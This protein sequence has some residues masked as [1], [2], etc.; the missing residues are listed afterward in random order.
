MLHSIYHLKHSTTISGVKSGVFYL[1][2]EGGEM[3]D[4]HD[5][6]FYLVFSTTVSAELKFFW[7]KLCMHTQPL[8]EPKP[9]QS[10]EGI[11]VPKY[12]LQ[13]VLIVLCQILPCWLCGKWRIPNLVPRH[14][15]AFH[16]FQYGNLLH[17]PLAS[18]RWLSYTPSIEC[19]VSWTICA[20]NAA[21][22]FSPFSDYVMLMW[23]TIPTFP[24]WK[25]GRD[26]RIRL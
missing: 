16:C 2:W 8:P 25:A 24:R 12:L 15:P 9:P 7:R 13:T 10:T 19:A 26:L 23:E 6:Y 5:W 1:C 22:K 14:R 11:G 17:A 18:G 3:G 21:W 20:W 4:K